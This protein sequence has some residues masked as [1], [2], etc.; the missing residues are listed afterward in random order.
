M[1]VA[2]IIG[3]GHPFYN[4]VSQVKFIGVYPYTMPKLF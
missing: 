2:Q 3:A 4:S 1:Q